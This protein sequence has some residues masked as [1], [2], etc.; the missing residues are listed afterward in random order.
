MFDFLPS[1]NVCASPSLLTEAR[2]LAP[3]KLHFLITRSGEFWDA[4]FTKER[5]GSTAY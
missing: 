2:R 3:I 5:M 1:G 4:S